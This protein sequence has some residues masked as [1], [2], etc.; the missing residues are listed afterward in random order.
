[1]EEVGGNKVYL[2]D[3]VNVDKATFI[4]YH[5]RCLLFGVTPCVDA[6]FNIAARN[7]YVTVCLSQVRDSSVKIP[8]FVDGISSSGGWMNIHIR[9]LDL[10]NV[11]TLERYSLFNYYVKHISSKN[12]R[13]ISDSALKGASSLETLDAPRLRFLGYKGLSGCCNLTSLNCPDLRVMKDGCLTG[14]YMLES[15]DVPHIELIES[16]G[17]SYLKIQASN[18][19]KIYRQRCVFR[20]MNTGNYYIWDGHQCEH[21][22]FNFA[23]YEDVND[24]S[25]SDPRGYYTYLQGF[26]EGKG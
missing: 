5:S 17:L 10:N 16:L 4:D 2:R 9:E 24:K 11:Q 14:C 23:W 12:L 25:L 15:L 21:R 22:N 18:N 3:L 20:D 19:F 26:S 8:D 1:M 7:N 13:V 6:T